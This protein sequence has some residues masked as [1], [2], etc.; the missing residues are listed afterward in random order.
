MHS[1]LT[2]TVSFAIYMFVSRSENGEIGTLDSPRAFTCLALL[3]LC[4]ESLLALLQNIANVASAAGCIGHIQELLCASEHEASQN[5]QQ[6][7]FPVESENSPPPCVVAEDVSTGWHGPILHNLSFRIY[8]S[9]LTMLIGPVGCGKS[10]LLQAILGETTYTTGTILVNASQIAYCSQ[11]PW[12]VNDTI[13]QNVLGASTFCADRY[14]QTI[15]ACGLEKDIEL[16]PDGD[17]TFVGTQGVSLS[18][19]QKQRLVR[20]IYVLLDISLY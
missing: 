14:K 5:R 11:T 1:I 13:R 15:R 18:G 3:E 10:T 20:L 6:L 17:E 19:G 2:P 12:L 8:P 7:S 4:G 16:F 9:S